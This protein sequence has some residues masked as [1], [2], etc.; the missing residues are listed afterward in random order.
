MEEV[1]RTTKGLGLRHMQL[2]KFN[3]CDPESITNFL[4][5]FSRGRLSVKDAD[6]TSFTN[7]SDTLVVKLKS[8]KDIETAVQ[9]ALKM[10]EFEADEIHVKSTTKGV[11][12]RVW[13]D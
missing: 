11:F 3:L 1:Q 13:W 4:I 6:F 2:T 8:V 7:S 12:I 9:F 10:K 5:D